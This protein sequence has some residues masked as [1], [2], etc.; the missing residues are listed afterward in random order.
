[1]RAPFQR[2]FLLL[3]TLLT[4]RVVAQASHY[5][6][7][8]A[9]RIRGG[10]LAADQ[11]A[12]ELGY[13]NA[14]P[15]RGLE[16][17]YLLR[18]TGQ[19]ER[20]R[21]SAR[22]VTRRLTQDARVLW[23]E[24]QVVR[25]REK[26]GGD[27]M[28]DVDWEALRF[29]DPL[30]NRQWYIH[31]T[32]SSPDLPE[33]DHR[34]TKVWDMG[35]T[36]KGVTVT[37]MDDGL[38]WNHTD[39][40]QNY[41]PEASYD[42]NDDD[43]DPSPRYDPQDLNNHGTRCA[44]EVAMAANN[45]NCGVGVAYEARIGG[46]RMLDGDVVDAVESTS[47]AFNVEGI[48]VFSASWGP[49]DDGR[50][51]DGP[52][53]LASEALRRGVTRGRGGRG[54]VY[55]WASGNG[56]A[57]GDNCNCDGYAGSPYTL[58]VSSASQRGRF[59]YYGE[60]CASTMAAAYS[61]GAYTDQKVATSDLH[62]SCT[63][64]HTGTSASAPL[65]AGIVALVLQA[66]PNLGWRDVQHLVAWT[67]DFAPLSS[68]RGWKRNAAGL[69]Y[70]SRFGFGLLDAQAMVQAALNWTNVGPRDRCLLSPEAPWTLPRSM[71]SSGGDDGD[72]EV[73]LAFD[74]Q[75]CPLEALEHVQ[76]HLD[77]EYSQRGALDAYLRSPAGTESVLLY[78]RAKDT[79]GQGFH[80]WSFLTVHLWGENPRG[81]WTLVIRDKFGQNNIGSLNA[82]F[83]TLSGTREQPAYQAARNGRRRYDD[84]QLAHEVLDP[85][86]EYEESEEEEAQREDASR[87]HKSRLQQALL[88]ENLLH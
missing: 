30:W 27:F 56:G 54:S 87:E 62:N 81:L 59:P 76:V 9:V 85:V 52:K 71:A 68:N 58:S 44:G 31:D 77:L 72:R 3:C 25:V 22:G 48:D 32:R 57:K 73:Q 45:R 6:N 64:Q 66:N 80:N 50:T 37:I 13:A 33:L 1:M 5:L 20:S 26:R 41:A 14:G 60:K 82:V 40:V 2:T 11:L 8:W 55:V 12:R 51:V 79:T 10:P 63:T 47:L 21:R 28:T 75:N 69:L 36:G 29:N 53:R 35:F 86:P 17:T 61:S 83:M 19:P 38:E 15:L 67:S 42:F 39:L 4:A 49:S 78:R 43:G 46:I 70:N 23:A 16:D 88:R 65:A 24:Q 18:K 74:A 7:A 84:E 34:V